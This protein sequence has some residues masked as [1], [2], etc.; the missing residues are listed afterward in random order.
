M[1]VF[2]LTRT[3]IFAHA[4]GDTYGKFSIVVFQHII[5]LKDGYIIAPSSPSYHIH[6]YVFHNVYLVMRVQLEEK[7]KSS[8]HKILDTST[9]CRNL[10]R[11]LPFKLSCNDSLCNFAMHIDKDKSFDPPISLQGHAHQL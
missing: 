2:T 10:I 6:V 5:V 3:L 1:F 4:L 7:V 11:E 9:R 8:H